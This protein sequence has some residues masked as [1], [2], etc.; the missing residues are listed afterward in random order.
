M[1]GVSVTTH[2]LW[3]NIWIE[4][5]WKQTKTPKSDNVDVTLKKLKLN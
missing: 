1:N 2:T 3:I 5:S 4:N